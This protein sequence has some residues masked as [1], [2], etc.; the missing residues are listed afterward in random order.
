LQDLKREASICCKLKHPHIVELF[1]T[2]L[3]DGFLNMVFE[4]MDGADLCFE[5]EKRATA[6]FVYS[7]S[8]ASH[9]MRQILDAVRYCH[10]SNV[11]HRDIKPHCVL[12]SSKEN[13]APIKLGGFGIA[14][15][16]PE[17][18]EQTGGGGGVTSLITSGRI[19]TPNYMSPEVV[20]RLPYSKPVDMWGCGIVLFVLLSGY[21]PFVGSNRRLF[22]LISQGQYIVRVLIFFFNGATAIN[23]TSNNLCFL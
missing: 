17:E 6:G 8:V 12:L 20:Q 22:E 21:L 5:I 4:Y 2:Y 19:G 9:Y 7:E 3:S 18:D 1:E 15:E 13:S 11:I 23:L 14:I 16:L 10:Q